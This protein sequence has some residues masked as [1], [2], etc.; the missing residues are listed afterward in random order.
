MRKVFK[1]IQNCYYFGLKHWEEK[2][3]PKEFDT[4][5]EARQF[6][7]ELRDNQGG[8]CFTY[9]IISRNIINL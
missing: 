7:K 5:V 6:A 4:E 8:D 3:Y 2:E 1:I 9:R